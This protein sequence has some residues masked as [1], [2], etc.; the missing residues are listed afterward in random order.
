[1]KYRIAAILSFA[2]FL[3]CALPAAGQDS[4]NEQLC[5]AAE[6]GQ[7]DAVQHLLKQGASVDAHMK[8]NDTSALI[9]AAGEGHTDVVRFLLKNGAKVD[10]EGW[11]GITALGS[12]TENGHI[13][14]VQL[15]LEKGANIEKESGRSGGTALSYAALK[16]HADIVKLLLERGAKVQARSWLTGDTALK[17]AAENGETEIALLLLE[18]CANI[19]DKDK[20]GGT[21]L[22]WAV[23]SQNA[24][25][26]RLLLEKGANV[27]IKD[28]VGDTALIW[29]AN[30]HNAEIAR[31]LLEK[32]ANIEDKDK[33]G[34]SALTCE[35]R[36]MPA[37]VAELMEQ[38]SQ[39]RKQL[40]QAETKQ[41]A[42]R[43]ATYL[44][45]F[46]KNP[47]DDYI[48]E[49]IVATGS[50]LSPSP[51]IPEEARQFFLLASTQIKQASGPQTLAQPI[52]LLRKALEIAPWWGNAYYNLSRA[53][54]MSGEYDDDS[55]QLNY[56]LEL[57]PP[58]ADAREARA[59]IVVIQTEKETAAAHRKQ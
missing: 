50:S 10:T 44:S 3:F 51:A 15:L 2:A 14:I 22:Q 28:N 43:F 57:K 21:P 11:M 20:D 46:G 29:A 55:K 24:A 49:K 54:E 33:D 27:N 25:I 13:D 59:H 23:N 26:V 37:A 12:A 4:L 56:Y 1:M 48:R 32:S 42:E 5:N 41:P 36:M 38:A 9:L 58:E 17:C 18:K 8:S 52:A 53:L 7:L 34:D 31:M 16:G 45:A 19:E 47:Q 40:E 6:A 39:R 35:G 30:S